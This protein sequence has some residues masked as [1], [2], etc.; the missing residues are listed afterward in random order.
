M[1]NRSMIYRTV[2]SCIAAALAFVAGFAQAEQAAGQPQA[3]RAETEPTFADVSYGPAERNV[4]DF[5]QAAGEKPA[6]L[7]VHIHA[8][9][10]VAG[11][12]KGI[13]AGMVGQQKVERLRTLGGQTTYDPI[14][15]SI[16]SREE[17]AQ[18]DDQGHDS[19]THYLHQQSGMPQ[20]TARRSRE[21]IG[22]F[23][24]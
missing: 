17:A 8:G 19:Q 24:D 6:P 2:L 10:F 16:I 23:G 22:G 18:P 20:G 3:G 9:G 13:N 7:L 11:D 15:S 5:Y 21:G 12:K 4:L 14:I 1:L